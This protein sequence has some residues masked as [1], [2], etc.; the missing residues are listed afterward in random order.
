VTIWDVAGQ[1]LRTLGGHTA[2]V[3]RVA[4]N[5]EG[6]LIAS[7]SWDGTVRLWGVLEE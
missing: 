7:S 5:P 1:L 3:L 6:T 2:E 4:C